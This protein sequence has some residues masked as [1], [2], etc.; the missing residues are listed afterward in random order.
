M[1]ANRWWEHL[2]VNLSSVIWPINHSQPLISFGYP[3]PIQLQS[4]KNVWLSKNQPHHRQTLLL[5]WPTLTPGLVTTW[6]NASHC[7]SCCSGAGAWLILPF[8]C[9]LPWSQHPHLCSDHTVSICPSVCLSVCLTAS[10]CV[11]LSLCLSR[12]VS[13]AHNDCVCVACCVCLTVCA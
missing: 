1:N 5:V 2:V 13:L 10:H 7:V 4:N 9:T 8:A 3:P 6:L 12:C 11:C